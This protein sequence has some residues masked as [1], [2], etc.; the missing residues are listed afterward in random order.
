[1]SLIDRRLSA[2]VGE[3]GEDGIGGAG[4]G[5][6][7]G[8]QLGAGA[9]QRRGFGGRAV[10]NA[11]LMPALDEAQGDGCP[12]S[13]DAGDSNMHVRLLPM[14]SLSGQITSTRRPATSTPAHAAGGH[15]DAGRVNAREIDREIDMTS[16]GTIGVV[17]LGIMG[18]AMARNL[19]ADG[20]RVFGYDL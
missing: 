18:G 14:R 3:N 6:G 4:Q 7:C 8:G 12:H 2:G 1:M 10:P 9:H 5:G 20:W 19:N 17:G 16:R 13:P 11:E 15:G